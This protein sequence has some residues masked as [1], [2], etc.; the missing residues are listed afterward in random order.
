MFID[1]VPQFDFLDMIYNSIYIY[2]IIYFLILCYVP[3]WVSWIM[4]QMSVID[5]PILF[6]FGWWLVVEPVDPIPLCSIARFTVL[7]QDLPV[8]MWRWAESPSPWAVTSSTRRWVKQCNWR[9][10]WLGMVTVPPIKMVKLGSGLLL[11]YPHYN[12]YNYIY[13]TSPTYLIRKSGLVTGY[14]PDSSPEVLLGTYPEI[15][16]ESL[17]SF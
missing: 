9:Q 3:H 13:S 2:N 4:S 12:I 16:C 17:G 5:F 8:P 6:S 10:P 1:F 15:L 14:W 11:F 7:G